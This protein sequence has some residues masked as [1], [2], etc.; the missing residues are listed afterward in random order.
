MHK[1]KYVQ[2]EFKAVESCVWIWTFIVQ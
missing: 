2:H 1:I